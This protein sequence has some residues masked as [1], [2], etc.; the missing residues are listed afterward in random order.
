MGMADKFASP[1]MDLPQSF[2]TYACGNERIYA[3]NFQQIEEA[4]GRSVIDGVK[5]A[6]PHSWRSVAAVLYLELVSFQPASNPPGGHVSESR[7]L[8]NRIDTGLQ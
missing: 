7:G 3:P 8:R 4:K 5:L 2:P 1:I 6:I